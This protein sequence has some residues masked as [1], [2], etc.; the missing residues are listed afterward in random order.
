MLKA[1]A[2]MQRDAA[3]VG[4]IDGSDERMHLVALARGVDE[5]IHQQLAEA[6]AAM[7]HVHIDRML[8]RVLVG[9][10]SAK[11]AP[12]RKAQQLAGLRVFDADD[13]QIAFAL[14]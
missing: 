8:D 3:A 2:F 6:L 5:C 12:A 11:R 7:V 4:R 13:G 14:A 10:I 9:R 1:E